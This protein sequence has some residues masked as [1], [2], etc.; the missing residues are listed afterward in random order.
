MMRENR[1]DAGDDAGDAKRSEVVETEV[2]H[3]V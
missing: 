3:M 2:D 1:D